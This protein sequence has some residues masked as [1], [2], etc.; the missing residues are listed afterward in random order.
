MYTI[1]IDVGGTN[2]KA[3]LVDG[4]GK[5]LATERMP[6]RWVSPEKFAADLT[7]LALEIGRAHV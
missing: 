1:G 6:L 2:L 7:A 5:L 4:S 3:G